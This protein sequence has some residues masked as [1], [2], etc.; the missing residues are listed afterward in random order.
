M[1]QEQSSFYTLW[2]YN[3]KKLTAWPGFVQFGQ[4][5]VINAIGEKRYA[6]KLIAEREAELL[7]TPTLTAQPTPAP[8]L[9]PTPAIAFQWGLE[10][11]NNSSLIVT[12]LN[13]T[14]WPSGYPKNAKILLVDETDYYVPNTIPNMDIDFD[15]GSILTIQGVYVKTWYVTSISSIQ[16]GVRSTTIQNFT[17][18]TMDVGSDCCYNSELTAVIPKVA[19]RFIKIRIRGGY[20]YYSSTWGLRRVKI[21]GVSNNNS[22]TVNNIGAVSPLTNLP[23]VAHN[24]TENDTVKI[25]AKAADGSFLGI[26]SLRSPNLIRSTLEQ[27]LISTPM[28]P[29]STSAWSATLP[30]N[31]LQENTEL[32]V[33]TIDP[34]DSTNLLLYRLVLKGL[35]QFSEHTLIRT[36]VLIFGD[37][38][39]VQNLDTFTH[40]AYDLATGM[41]NAMPLATLHWV[42]S[43]DWH[44]PYLVTPTLT[45]PRLVHNET[46]RRTVISAAGGDPGTEPG[47]DILKNQFALRHSLAHTGRGFTIT[48]TDGESSPYA[49]GTSIFMGWALTQQLNNSWY[50]DYLGYWSGWSAAAWTGRCTISHTDFD[51]NV[52]HL[53]GSCL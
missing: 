21:G 38:L 20:S 22:N 11:L 5:H 48:N 27:S 32:L 19:S 46:E 33:G 40:G 47:W 35:V 10:Q 39:D 4:T 36:K 49:S 25:A 16:I 30:W 31:W 51:L 26:I 12:P 6:P 24:L 14:S 53:C 42:D 1:T 29:Y 37:S 23:S 44:V 43:Q 41:F 3:V 13:S 8:T 2:G 45:G 34:N 7:F 15:L 9:A 28:P 18:F 52:F 17:W 50:W